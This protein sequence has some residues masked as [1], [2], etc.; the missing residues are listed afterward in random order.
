[1][2]GAIARAVTTTI[3]LQVVADLQQVPSDFGAY[4]S[5]YAFDGARLTHLH[6]MARHRDEQVK[7]RARA[8]S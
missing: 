1:M 4:W 2:T 8:G 7:L 6:E 3:K 5:V